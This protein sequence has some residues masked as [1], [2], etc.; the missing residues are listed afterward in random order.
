MEKCNG[1]NKQ[2]TNMN[3][4]KTPNGLSNQKKETSEYLFQKLFRYTSF[5]QYKNVLQNFCERY[6]NKNY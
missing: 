6:Y 2:N 3:Y 4:K 1:K 5:N